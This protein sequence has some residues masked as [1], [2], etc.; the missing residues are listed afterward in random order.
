MG[1]LKRLK[2]LPQFL[3]KKRGGGGGGGVGVATTFKCL[4][5]IYLINELT[6]ASE[7]DLNPPIGSG[8]KG[9]LTFSGIK[10]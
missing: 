8:Q 4:N 3:K 10:S 6:S 5:E 2:T 9:V 7:S 1:L